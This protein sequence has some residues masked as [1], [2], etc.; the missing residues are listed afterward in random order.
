MED[1]GII[2][3]IFRSFGIYF[4][5]LVYHGIENNQPI[6]STLCCVAGSINDDEYVYDL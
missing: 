3:Y 5:I 1:F 2:W 4:P 6:H